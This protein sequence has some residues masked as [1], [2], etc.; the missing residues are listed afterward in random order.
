MATEE[1]RRTDDAA[2]PLPV[3]QLGALLH[4]KPQH[5]EQQ[6]WGSAFVQVRVQSLLL[7]STS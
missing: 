2:E 6:F 1:R 3:A 7:E 4:I 5:L